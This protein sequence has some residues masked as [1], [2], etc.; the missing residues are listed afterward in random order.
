MKFILKRWDLYAKSVLFLLIFDLNNPSFG[1]SDIAQ[2]MV[3]HGKIIE[4][5]GRDFI[6]K[7]SGGSKVTI[8]FKRN[9]MLQE[10]TGRNLNQGDEFEPGDGLITLS[11][12]AQRLQSK[13]MRPRGFWRLEEDESLG[14]IYEFDKAI[15]HAKTGKVI[16][17]NSKDD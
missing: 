14:W 17:L 15:I 16:P 10:A 9:G 13:G 4:I 8:E 11:T 7:T 5:W 12:A 3:P 2:S 6:L 1:K